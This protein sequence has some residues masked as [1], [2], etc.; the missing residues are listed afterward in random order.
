MTAD[1][2]LYSIFYTLLILTRKSYRVTGS[3]VG[4]FKAHAH[5][6]SLKD[7]MA[8]FRGV[9]L[10]VLEKGLTVFLKRLLCFFVY[11]KPRTN[12]RWS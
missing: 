2:R 6:E 4:W 3:A 1:Y 10:G 7:E 11:V 12:D 8:G 9:L 5:S